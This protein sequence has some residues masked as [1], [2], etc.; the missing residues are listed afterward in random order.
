[1]LKLENSVSYTTRMYVSVDAIDHDRVLFRPP[2]DPLL[3]KE[4][5]SWAPSPCQGE[6]WGEVEM[7]MKHPRL[8]LKSLIPRKRELRKVATQAEQVLWRYLRAKRLKGYKFRRQ[9]GIGPYIVDFCAPHEGIV[10]EIDGDIHALPDHK[11]KDKIRQHEIE[12]LGFRVIRYTNE[13]VLKN[14]DAVLEDILSCVT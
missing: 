10:I 4:G 13:A 6:G 9:H 8:G 12:A 1:M 7:A 5:G 11:E 14:L 2:P 3:C